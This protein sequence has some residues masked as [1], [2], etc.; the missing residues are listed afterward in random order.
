MK[1]YWND[2]K[3]GKNNAEITGK[4][5]KPESQWTDSTR[6]RDAVLARDLCF[7]ESSGSENDGDVSSCEEE[8]DG[9]I[10]NDEDEEEEESVQPRR[11]RRKRR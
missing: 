8:D 11:K 7:F 9:Y 10:D 5:D 4:P 2:L 3:T 1:A 6:R